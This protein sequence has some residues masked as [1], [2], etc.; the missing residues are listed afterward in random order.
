MRYLVVAEAGF[1]ASCHEEAV[2]AIE[3]CERMNTTFKDS[4]YYIID[5][6]I[7]K[8]HFQLEDIYCSY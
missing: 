5:N 6:D 7:Q 1:V 3:Y 2:E 4:F 8:E